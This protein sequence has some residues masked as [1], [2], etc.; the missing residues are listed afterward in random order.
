MRLLVI[1]ALLAG[2]SQA[3]F[4]FLNDIPVDAYYNEGSD[5]VIQWKPQDRN[6]TFRLELYTFL[7]DPIYVGPS[8]YPRGFPIYEYNGTT[9][10]LDDAAK[11]SVGNYTWHIDLIEG[12]EG[13][14]WFYRFGAILGTVGE[15][16]NYARAFHIQVS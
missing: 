16:A 15:V 13:A 3:L 14:D 7:T 10:V 11:Y 5:L 2:A 9:T 4:Q 6:D 1:P 12:R 8:P